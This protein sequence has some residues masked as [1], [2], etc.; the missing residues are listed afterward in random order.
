MLLFL[1]FIILWKICFM[2]SYH[3]NYVQVVVN[4]SQVPIV[5]SPENLEVNRE[6][7][8]VRK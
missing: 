6:N 5:L 1:A 8:K 3:S 7:L 2:I 4:L